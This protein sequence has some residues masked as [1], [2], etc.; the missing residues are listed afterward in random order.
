M[1]NPL[2]SATIKSLV[3]LAQTKKVPNINEL[4]SEEFLL[5][6]GFVDLEGASFHFEIHILKKL[7]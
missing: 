6:V 2:E 1:L 7:P 4:V 3:V 5:K